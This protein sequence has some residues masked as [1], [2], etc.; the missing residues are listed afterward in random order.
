VDSESRTNFRSLKA[1]YPPALIFTRA[2]QLPIYVGE[3]EGVRKTMKS[4]KI[5][6][7]L[8]DCIRT[9]AHR[10]EGIHVLDVRKRDQY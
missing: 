4:K 8:N 1:G 2:F 10:V 6:S 7:Q 3:V 9:A 5:V